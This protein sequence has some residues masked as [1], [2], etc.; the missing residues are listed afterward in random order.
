[1]PDD[2]KATGLTAGQV[3][4]R[5]RVSRE[6]VNE[7]RRRGILIGVRDGRGWWRFDPHTVE[8]LDANAVRRIAEEVQ[9]EAHA[10][11]ERALKASAERRG[12]TWEPGAPERY[13]VRFEVTDDNRAACRY[14]GAEHL[15]WAQ[16]RRSGKWYLVEAACEDGRWIAH[17]YKFHVC[18]M[19]QTKQAASAPSRENLTERLSD[20]ERAR[21]KRIERQLKELH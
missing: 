17:R 4:Q 2:V 14:C 20:E 21:L 15:A 19:F 16:G 3:M 10:A 6:V 8:G 5:L 13:A 12:E 9:V 18:P 7:L 11:A 1:M